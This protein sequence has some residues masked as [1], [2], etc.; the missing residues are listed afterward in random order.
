MKNTHIN[1][2]CSYFQRQKVHVL[3]E[4]APGIME[5]GTQVVSPGVP[6]LYMLNSLSSEQS[7]LSTLFTLLLV[8][9]NRKTLDH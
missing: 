5:T 2:K 6:D 4:V 1:T 9:V 3:T 8:S 7:L